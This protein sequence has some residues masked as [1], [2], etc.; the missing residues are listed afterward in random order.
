MFPLSA[1]RSTK[2]C[3]SRGKRFSIFCCISEGRLSHK[4]RHSFF[5]QPQTGWNFLHAS[6]DWISRS[7]RTSSALSSETSPRRKPYI[8]KLSTLKERRIQKFR[9]I[10]HTLRYESLL[11]TNQ[12]RR[13]HPARSTQVIR[14]R[15]RAA[16]MTA[17]NIP[18]L[19]KVLVQRE[20]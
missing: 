10:C 16:P 1:K 4:E 9:R 5:G 3:N 8:V 19:N 12:E 6:L 17:D 2:T 13:S 15:R 18:G 20:R 7:A 11:R 14:Q